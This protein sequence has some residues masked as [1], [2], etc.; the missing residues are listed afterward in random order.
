V[1]AFCVLD[2]FDPLDAFAAWRAR[3][4]T[5]LVEGRRLFVVDVPA[6]APHPT[7]PDAP[8]LVLL[9]GFPSWS[10]DF[11]LIVD[12]LAEHHRVVAH[13]LLGF[14]LSDK[15]RPH[16]YS[17]AEQAQLS[18]SL[19][20]ML[21][22]ERAHLVAH[23]YGTS[24]A[25]EVL[26]QTAEQTSGFRAQSLTLQ[27]GS[28]LIELAQLRL[29]Q[30]LLL[31]PLGPLY[32]RL[33]SRRLYLRNMRALLR[34]P[35]D[36]RHLEGMWRAVLHDN[37][38]AVLPA[39]TRYIPERRALRARHVEALVRF[40]GPTL[41]LWGEDDPVAV[42]A[43]GDGLAALLPRARHVRLTGVGHYP[44]LEAPAA[45]VDAIGTLVAPAP[46]RAAG[47]VS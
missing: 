1:V 41:L 15:P 36:D 23:D 19:W 33:A 25:A 10:G 20:R 26:A 7:Q 34:A 2:A 45:C 29:G 18:L 4:S 5:V 14:G 17:F 16:P 47:S 44:S 46:S 22:I 40:A 13:D 28:I 3:G 24:V 6:R 30:R 37:G 11:A 27:N 8:T 35:V 42:R 21:G 43:I 12:A 31:S 38:P 39:L 32:A 9:H